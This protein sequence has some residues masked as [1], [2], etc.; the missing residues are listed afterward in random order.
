MQVTASHDD[1]LRLVNEH[2]GIV[3]KVCHIYCSTDEDRK[4]LFQEIV[5]QLW[6]SYPKFRGES[7]FSTW[8]YRIA[9]NTAISDFR[10]QK[11]KPRVSYPDSAPFEI[12]DQ[13]HDAEKEEKLRM[14]YKAITKLSEVEKALVMLYLDDRSYDEMEEVLGINQNNLRV[15][16]KRVKDKLRELTKTTVYGT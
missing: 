5:I 6:K 9:L 3:H 8:M 11:R 1:F 16:M 7:R 15:K 12:A 10:R 14:L 4:D 13:P 2:S